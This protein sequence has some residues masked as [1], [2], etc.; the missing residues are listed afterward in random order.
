M[1]RAEGRNYVK[2]EVGV[3]FSPLFTWP[4]SNSEVKN[5]G[6][7]SPLAL[8]GMVHNDSKTEDKFTFTSD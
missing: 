4:L 5:N 8:H 6:F 1:K 3:S 2:S 7:M